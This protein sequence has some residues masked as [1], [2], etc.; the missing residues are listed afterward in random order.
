MSS[1][2]KKTKFNIIDILIIVVLLVALAVGV[3][4][5]N[6]KPTVQNTDPRVATAI[7]ELREVEKSLLDSIQV[8]DDIFLTVDNVD[9]AKVVAVSEPQ[10][11]TTIGLDQEKGEFKYSSSNNSKYTGYITIEADVK[12]DD[13]NIYA[14]GTS[15]KV[16]KAVF[17]KGKGY[18]AKGYVLEL[19]TKAKGE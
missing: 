11:T 1:K 18:S 5:L 10:Q 8:G 15:L 19:D 7:V 17:I 6:M 4:I 12:E 13:A 9:A 2:E 14:G 16:G 3:R